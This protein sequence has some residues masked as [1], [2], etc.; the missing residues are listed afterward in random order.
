MPPAPWKG[1]LGRPGVG[2][3]PMSGYWYRYWCW[4][5]YWPS[6]GGIADGGLWERWR[7]RRH[8]ISTPPKR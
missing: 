5:W 6:V 1:A 3:S 2:A 4:Y 8:S 7:P